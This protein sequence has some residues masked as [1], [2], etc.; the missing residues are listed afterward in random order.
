VGAGAIAGWIR[1][2][3]T[4]PAF[5]PFL[6]FLTVGFVA[7]VISIF[8]IR[9]KFTNASVYNV[10][11]IL[12]SMLLIYLFTR[13]GFF[14]RMRWL[15]VLCYVLFPVV[16][17]SE[18]IYRGDLTSF[19][20]FFIIGYSFLI[21]FLSINQLQVVLFTEPF[22]IYQNPVFLICLGLV[23]YFTSTVLI[24]FFWVYG[25]NKSG[26]FR[27]HVVS[28]FPF[29]NLFSN[30]VFLIAILWIPLK[31]RYLLRSSSVL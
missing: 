13:W 24:E 28:I 18:W 6:L 30:F 23:L 7:E 16:C 19:C 3:K 21:I 20:S 10:Y 5:L 31:P 25:L 22:R 9:F 15:P 11:S 17:I 1:I 2:R 27:K 8:L 12:E 29:V 4:D 14:V 26:A